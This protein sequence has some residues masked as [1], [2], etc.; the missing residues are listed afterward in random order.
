[1]GFNAAHANYSCLYYTVKKDERFVAI[2][3]L[4]NYI[5]IRYDTTIPPE[6]YL[7][8]RARSLTSIIKCSE[9]KSLGV[10]HKPLWEIELQ[11]VI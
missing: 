4:K 10:L 11:Q 7:T 8:T 5:T 1:M 9:T 2:I 6:E 3:I